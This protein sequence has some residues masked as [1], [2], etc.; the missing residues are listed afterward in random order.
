MESQIGMTKR[1]EQ[2]MRLVSSNGIIFFMRHQARGLPGPSARRP[3]R[4]RR[5]LTLPLPPGPVP[6]PGRAEGQPPPPLRLWRRPDA[7]QAAARGRA[8]AA[9]HDHGQQGSKAGL[10]GARGLREDPQDPRRTLKPWPVGTLQIQVFLLGGN[11]GRVSR[12]LVRVERNNVFS[13]DHSSSLELADAY[14]LGGVP[15][16][17]LPPR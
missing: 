4:A 13:V 1:F 7:G 12:V 2:E 5:V 17:Q 14:Y 8:E 3:L 11:R 9:D 10:G 16:D 15:P 6:V